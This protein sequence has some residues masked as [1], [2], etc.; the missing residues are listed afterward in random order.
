M[1]RVY[2]AG[3]YSGDEEANVRRAI[4]AFA[5]LHA[6]GFL[7]FAPHLYHA[8]GLVYPEIGYEAWMA[9]CFAELERCDALLRLSGASKGADREVAHALL[10][11]IPVFP[12][13]EALVGWRERG[14]L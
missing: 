1:I 2:V 3:P 7:P 10:K 9:L 12:H 6:L 13:I 4:D 11:G 5:Q 8:V 14:T